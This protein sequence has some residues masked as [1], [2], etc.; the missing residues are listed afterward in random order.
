MA[1]RLLTLLEN[2]R[3]E[4]IALKERNNDLERLNSTLVAENDALRRDIESAKAERD[5]A[6]LDVEFMAVS[7]KLADNPDNLILA[8]RKI[9]RLIRNIDRCLEMMKE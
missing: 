7:H 3:R 9:A 4:I 8:R 2:L 1:N 5:K 6:I